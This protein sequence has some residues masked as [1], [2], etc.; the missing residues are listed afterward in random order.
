[1]ELRQLRYF[2][3]AAETLN[4]SDAAKAL[5]IAQSSLSQQIKQLEDE[6]NVQLFLRNSHSIRL[7]E[8]GE[9]MLPFAL[10]TIHDAETCADRIH[11]LQKLLTGTLNIGITYSF[12][13]ILTETVISFMK[14]YPHIK[15]NIIYKP[16]SELME[17]LAKRDLDFVLAFKPTKPVAD[18]ESHILFQNSLSAIVSSTHPLASKDKVTLAE[19]GKYELALPSKGLQARNAFDSLVTTYNDFQIRIELNE[20]NILLKL[21]RQT[22]LVTV[23]AEDSIYNECDVKAVPLDIPDNEMI[24]CVHILKDTYHKHSMKEFIRLL[25]ESLIVKKRQNSWI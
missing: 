24:G 21:I 7:T 10:R 13:P 12:S 23:L 9:E 4:F 8:A 6:L 25:S 19:L 1:M 18:V 22:H 11:D 5:N 16:M 14:M 20:V 15:L 17:L 2:A 3:K